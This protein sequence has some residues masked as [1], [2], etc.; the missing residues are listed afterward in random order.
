MQSYAWLLLALPLLGFAVTGGLGRRMGRTLSAVVGCG[1]IL[2][3][4]VVAI[5]CYLYVHGQA[6]PQTSNDMVYY[7]WADAGSFHLDLGL[8][9]DPLTCV[10]LLIVTGVGSLIHIY[11]V[12]YMEH[13]ANFSRFFSYLNLFIFSMLLLVLADNFL[14]LLVGW[15]LVGLSSYLLIGF[16][17]YRPSA[18]LAARKA[19]VMNVIGDFGMMIACYLLFVQFGTL[20]YVGVFSQAQ[21]MAVNTGIMNWI[22]LT[23]LIGAV[24]KSAQL[25][26]YTWLP[27]AMEGP[28]PVSA[29]I[30]AATMV[31]AG[32]YLLARA[33]VLYLLSPTVLGVVAIIGGVGALFAATIALVQT[34]IKR[35]LAYSTMSQIAYMFLA[36]GV[37]AFSAGVFHLVTH[38][39]FKAV[40]FLGAGSV[41]H[42]LHDEQ[43]LRKMGGLRARLPITYVLMGIGCLAIAG[44]PPFSG[45]MS[46]DEIL[47]RVLATGDWHVILWVL[48]VVT[49]ALTAFYMFRL[50]LMTFH[51][52]YNGPQEVYDHAH[53]APP[54]M[55]VP[56]G[57]L[58]VLAT[59]AGFLQF[60]G[61]THA[62]EDF[63][64]PVFT[65]YPA[66]YS[67]VSY[68]R[69]APLAANWT[70]IVFIVALAVVGI[71]LAVRMYGGAARRPFQGL[72]P[73]HTLLFNK[74]YVD[75]IYNELVVL[76]V[77]NGARALYNV[78]DRKGIDGIVNGVARAIGRVSRGLSPVESGFVRTYALSIFIGVVLVALVPLAFGTT[79][80]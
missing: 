25:P 1:V 23:L 27:D 66:V 31:T 48:G 3:A 45:F 6:G 20:S 11:S 58:G 26:L 62:F 8:L 12:G 40:L 14:I 35:V 41:I 65:Q 50:F 36:C 17:F 64:G 74:Y 77:R 57:V 21:H 73:L 13:D 51:G 10:M 60:P 47:G 71:A 38:A 9:I 37:G 49:A 33:H 59:V 61:R 7:R 4:F 72:K 56:V 16:W 52:R 54:V 76:P 46:K 44:I 55:W 68:A 39:F 32:V 29:L 15:G 5:A 19:F 24:A 63:L 30:H 78:V 53:E 70:V 69:P 75:E 2:V 79:I 42:A 34:D 80:K 28:T 22:C 67:K 18:V 43:D